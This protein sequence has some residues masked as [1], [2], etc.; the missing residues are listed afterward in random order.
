VKPPAH[1]I[2]VKSSIPGD[3]NADEWGLLVTEAIPIVLHKP[4]GLIFGIA[5]DETTHPD[6]PR[7][8]GVPL[9]Q[10]RDE[11]GN[12]RVIGKIATEKVGRNAVTI[13]LS[14]VAE[15]L[16]EVRVTKSA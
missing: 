4:T 9:G 15:Y 6:L 7:V 16:A 1:A 10:T 2:T 8:Y 12:Y 14:A 11:F 13:Y 5:E 3:V